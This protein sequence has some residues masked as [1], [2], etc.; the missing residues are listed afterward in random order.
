MQWITKTLL[1]IIAVLFSFGK[2]YSQQLPN[3]SEIISELQLV[4]DYWIQTHLDPGNNEWARA[5]YFTGNIDFYKVFAKK[6]Y[7]N[8]AENWARNHNWSLSGGTYTRFADNQTACQTYIDLYLIDDTLQDSRIDVTRQNVYNMVNST[9]SDDWWWIDALY[10]AMPV[11]ARIGHLYDDDEV[12][13]KMHDLYTDTKYSRSL[14]NETDGLWY[15]DQTF[16]P[17][18]TTP[19]GKDSYWSRG[20]GWVFGAHVRVL[21]ILPDTSR[22]RTEFIETFQKMAEALILRQR[23][24]GF[25]NVS[26]DDSLDYGGPETSG[27]SFFTYGLAWGINNGLLDSA[28]Y[29]PAV[30]KAWNG[31]TTIAIHPDGY[32][33]Y[34]QGV[35]TNPSSSQPVSYYT[36]ADFGVGAFLLA[37]SEVSKLADGEMPQPPVFYLDS[38]KTIAENQIQVF[39]NDSIDPSSGTIKDNYVI[40]SV[41]IDSITIGDNGTSSI[42]YVSNFSIGYHQIVIENIQSISGD[43]LA[44]G[45]TY[46]FLNNGGIVITASGFEP[47]SSNTPENSMDFNFNTRWS[48]EGNEEWIMYDLGETKIVTS[49]DI[50]FYRGNERNAYF[51]ISLSNDGI[52]FV[53]VFNGQSGG[54]TWWYENFDFLDQEARYVLITG[55]GNSSNYWNSITEVSINWMGKPGNEVSL[56]TLSIDVGTLSPEFDSSI[57]EYSAS[58]P[59]GTD[60][61]IVTATALDPNAKVYGDGVYYISSDT[62]FAEIYVVSANG[63]KILKYTID[64]SVK[65][66]TGLQSAAEYPISVY[67]NPFKDVFSVEIN[68]NFD[69]IIYNV[70]GKEIKKGNASDYIE[71]GHGL[72]TGIYQLRIIKDFNSNTYKIIKQ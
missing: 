23:N 34:V 11:F 15:R 29:Y 47:G 13:T 53:E 68:G 32:L 22:F 9:Q 16:A 50:A 8:Y 51:S 17:P 18:Y 6:N 35:G 56:S 10:M 4:N 2:L 45:E 39:F 37:G 14:Y 38:V 30:T 44:K 67:P 57:V 43:M 48:V 31:L 21:Q 61:V 64:I 49:V 25:W 62:A 52:T 24:D 60:S 59:Y 12:Y 40:D 3:K 65:T 19:N 41:I 69:Y 36:T 26:L 70:Y 28:T 54:V 66:T 46:K 1:A 58:V 33:G 42:L 72:T 20:N 55:M 63:I 27:T 7:L 5:A 71:L